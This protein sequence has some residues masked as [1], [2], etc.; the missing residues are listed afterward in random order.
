VDEAH[1]VLAD[2]DLTGCL[3]TGTVHLDQLRLEGDCAFDGAPRQRHPGPTRF[4]QPPY[5]H[6]G[7][8]LAGGPVGRGPGLEHGSV[9][10]RAR[11][12]RPTGPGVPGVDEGGGGFS[13]GRALTW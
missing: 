5:S 1:L 9:R 12:A 13:P 7:T 3:C 10:V 4:T 2:V 11:R 6:R 8:P